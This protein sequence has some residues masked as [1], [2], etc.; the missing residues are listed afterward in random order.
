MTVRTPPTKCLNCGHHLNRAGHYATDDA[1]EP[2][3]FTVCVYCGHLMAFAADLTMRE[4]TGE[5]IHAAAGLPDLL[6]AQQ[7]GAAFRRRLQ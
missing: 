2:G 1:P 4:L 5:E 7:F 6:R 3:N